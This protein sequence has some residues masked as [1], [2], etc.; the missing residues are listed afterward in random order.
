[1]WNCKSNQSSTL[2]KEVDREK[3]GFCYNKLMRPFMMSTLCSRAGPPQQVSYF[4]DPLMET[5][6][7]NPLKWGLAGR[8]T[9]LER[10]GFL[11]DCLILSL[12]FHS[13]SREMATLCP[14]LSLW[15]KTLLAVKLKLCRV[16]R[17]WSGELRDDLGHTERKRERLGGE[18]HKI[19]N[20]WSKAALYNPPL[21][22]L[23]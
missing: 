15:K 1:M 12:S 9:E 8:R 3:R 6:D 14:I 17:L 19:Q 11:T 7:F 5:D 10:E 13:L 23:L 21:I 22:R 2:L 18:V 4:H 20:I 16:R